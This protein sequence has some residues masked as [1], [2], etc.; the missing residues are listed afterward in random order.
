M[1]GAA[2]FLE[3]PTVAALDELIHVIECQHHGVIGSRVVILGDRA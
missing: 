1:H 2:Q 3:Q